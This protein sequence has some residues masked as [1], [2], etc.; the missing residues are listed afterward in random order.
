MRTDT[1]ESMII[2]CFG[3]YQQVWQL[4]N[5]QINPFLDGCYCCYLCTLCVFSLSE[6]GSAISIV[7]INQTKFNIGQ[8]IT[9]CMFS[10]STVYMTLWL[11]HWKTNWWLQSNRFLTMFTIQASCT[12]RYNNC[13]HFIFRDC[14]KKWRPVQTYGKHVCQNS[15]WCQSR[16]L[17]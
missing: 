2:E 7:K 4:Y 1:Q 11:C 8:Y 9:Y 5:L 10:P 12:V 6:R 17:K 3:F 16:S 13:M 14:A 15:H